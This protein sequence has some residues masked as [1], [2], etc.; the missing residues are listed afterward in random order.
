MRDC[1]FV[2]VTSTKFYDCNLD[3]IGPENILICKLLALS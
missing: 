1:V 2:S 3:A